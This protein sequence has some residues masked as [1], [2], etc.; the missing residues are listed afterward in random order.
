MS[1]NAGESYVL[2]HS[3]R[4]LERLE[5]QAG[6]FADMT[7]QILERAGIGAGMRVLDIGCGV[8]DGVFIAADLVGDGGS[9]VGIDI[10]EGAI[11]LARARAEAVGRSGVEFAVEAIEKFEDWSG[12]DAVIGRFI[13]IHMPDPAAAIARIAGAA[14][15]GTAIAFAEFDLGSAAATAPAPLFE[16]QVARIIEAYRKTGFEP[17][18]GS[19]LYAAFRGAAL[20]PELAAFTRVGSPSD[21][22]GF[23]FLTESVRSLLPAME[24]LSIATAAEVDIDTLAARLIA[25]A[26]AAD[27][28]YFYPRFVGGW[29]RT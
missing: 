8:G 12:F 20:R 15:P 13:L 29:A 21:R 28:C 11:E 16:A 18:M 25:E 6:F 26:E 3:L 19:K 24:K 14:K 10:S 22:A 9:V 17:E 5:Q 27:P 23:G 2:G 1:E 7:R 4:E